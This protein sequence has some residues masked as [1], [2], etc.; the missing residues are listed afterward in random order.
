MKKVPLFLSEGQITGVEP[1]STCELISFHVISTKEN[2]KEIG[3]FCTK[4]FK[5]SSY[6]NVDEYVLTFLAICF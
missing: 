4:M 3:C 2:I 1:Y 6:L 5:G